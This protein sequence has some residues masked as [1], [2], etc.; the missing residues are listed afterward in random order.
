MLNALAL[1]ATGSLSDAHPFDTAGFLKLPTHV[2]D[3]LMTPNE[4]STLALAGIGIGIIAVYAITQRVW[5][6]HQA[7]AT[8]K[9]F[10]TKPTATERRKRGAA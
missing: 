9:A 10:P 3:P 6:S 1:L 8:I 2:V 4:P 7:G 5:Q